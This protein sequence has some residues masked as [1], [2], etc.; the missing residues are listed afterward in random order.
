MDVGE[1]IDLTVD[2]VE[3]DAL[4]I[5]SGPGNF[6]AISEQFQCNSAAISEHFKSNFSAVSGQF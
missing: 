4:I 5:I 2:G 3:V 1:G 6:R